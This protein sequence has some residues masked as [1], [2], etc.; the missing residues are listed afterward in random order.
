MKWLMQETHQM[1]REQQ[2]QFKEKSKDRYDQKE[3]KLELKVGDKVIVQEK[4]S[5]G[6]L[7]HKW[8]F[9]TI[10]IC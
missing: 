7:A 4:A 5:K 9:R 1:V 3:S 2:I 8:P 6:K 10:N